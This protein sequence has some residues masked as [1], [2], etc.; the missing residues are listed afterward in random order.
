MGLELLIRTNLYVFRDYFIR[1]ITNQQW[2]VKLIM[3]EYKNDSALPSW[4]LFY[5]IGIFHDEGS[6]Y[7]TLDN[8]S[9]CYQSIQSVSS[10]R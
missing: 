8:M 10:E 5:D 1:I 2:N 6:V 7:I 9:Y 3:L 4:T